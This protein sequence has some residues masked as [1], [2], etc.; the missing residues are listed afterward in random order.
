MYFIFEC[1]WMYLI[2][3]CI[4]MYVIFESI[5]MYLIFECISYLN[6]FNCILYY[7]L[8]YGISHFIVF[9]CISYFNVYQCISYFNV[10]YVSLFQYI[11]MHLISII[12]VSFI[13][14]R[15]VPLSWRFANKQ[16]YLLTFSNIIVKVDSIY[17]NKYTDCNE[18]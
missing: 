13:L 8:F 2:F 16:Y 1:V 12:F 15:F 18:V 3:K 14:Y 10:L 17:S 4:S 11:S 6:V 5:W 7:N 9:Q